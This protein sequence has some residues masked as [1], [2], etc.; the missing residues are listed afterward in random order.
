MKKPQTGGDVLLKTKGPDYISKLAKKRKAKY[1][2]KKK[3]WEKTQIN[4]K[5]T[6]KGAK[7]QGK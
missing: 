7:T 3:E 1:K 6:V 5:S 2:K 4:K